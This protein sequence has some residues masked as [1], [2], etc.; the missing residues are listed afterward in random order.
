L[1]DLG[2]SVGA[3][4]GL[5]VAR[6]HIEELSRHALQDIGITVKGC[7]LAR[8]KPPARIGEATS[9]GGNTER[10]G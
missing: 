7:R 9:G 4:P 3:A 10:R 2:V 6:R 1:N 8:E 5:A